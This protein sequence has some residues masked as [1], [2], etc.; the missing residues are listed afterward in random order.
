MSAFSRLAATSARIIVTILH[1]CWI[2]YEK[3]YVD[4]ELNGVNVWL[5][6]T[7]RN[8]D[9]DDVLRCRLIGCCS[10]EFQ[11]PDWLDRL[12][13][14]KA[15]AH[16][17]LREEFQK[18]KIWTINGSYDWLSIVAESKPLLRC[19]PTTVAFVH[20]DNWWEYYAPLV[21]FESIIDHFVAV[22]PECA[23]RLRKDLPH[24]SE[25]I[26]VLPYFVPTPSNLADKH[27]AVDQPLTLIYAG[28]VRQSQ[29]RV[30]DLV[31]LANELRSRGVKFRLSICG[32]GDERVELMNRF[33]AAGHEDSVR[34][35]GK[36]DQSEMGTVLRAHDI[37]VQVSEY[38]GTSTSMLEA[39][40]NGVIP[41][42]TRA[43]SGISGIVE[44]G[45]N[46]ITVAIG[47]M[48]A[49]AERLSAVS[50]SPFMLQEMRRA[51]FAKGAEFGWSDYRTRLMSI[52][53]HANLNRRPRC[54]PRH[55]NPTP[56]TAVWARCWDQNRPEQHGRLDSLP[57]PRRVRNLIRSL[58]HRNR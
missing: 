24:R 53:E 2:P 22:S 40:A 55:L 27:Y 38:E 36:V 6:R 44:D 39:M 50:R 52:L 18:A 57:M 21:Y 13:G 10:G 31:G 56:D 3:G 28:R 33:D 48:V 54:W 14:T 47:D 7:K 34:Y 17:L 8:S 11:C 49:L 30:F 32:D 35:L 51:V 5:Q 42:V 37:F 43:T 23:S 20:N 41:A 19:M 15:A 58:I 46:G 9:G 29:K 26:S 45:L 25:S 16:R 4:P 12:I 1:T